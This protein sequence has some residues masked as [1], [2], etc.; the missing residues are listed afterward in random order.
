[1]IAHFQ[2]VAGLVYG[3]HIRIQRPPVIEADY[4][5]RHFY[6]SIDVQAICQPDGTFND[7]LARFPGS[8]HDSR[9]YKISGAGM[10]VE[11]TFPMGEHILG[12]SGYILRHIYSLLTVNQHQ[13]PSL[14]TIMHTKVQELLLN[15]RLC[16]GNEEFI[17][18]MEKSGIQIKLCHH[19]FAQIV[20]DCR[21]TWN[22]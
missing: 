2:G 3:T 17:V 18:F 19:S 20:S 15:K 22:L 21:V 10:Y 7:V 4:I 13:L 8:V 5:N 14:T 1:M 6:H 11:N 9:I 12:D 16:G